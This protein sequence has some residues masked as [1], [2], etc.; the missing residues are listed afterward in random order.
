MGLIRVAAA[1]RVAATAALYVEVVWAIASAVAGADWAES[2][3]I[4]FEEVANFSAAVDAA[5][6]GTT[7]KGVVEA[8]AALGD[9]DRKDNK[10]LPA[11]AD[12]M[13]GPIVDVDT[14][15]VT[16]VVDVGLL[17]I[18]INMAVL[19]ALGAATATAPSEVSVFTGLPFLG[20]LF[21]FSFCTSTARLRMDAIEGA[22]TG[23]GLEDTSDD[24]VRGAWVV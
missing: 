10:A 2:V 22:S 9:A 3:E 24:G 13:E 16:G 19:L 5:R 21:F 12:T 7:T 8:E 17:S 14:G 4:G 11:S 20:F 15:A 18:D 6:A 23:D 1:A